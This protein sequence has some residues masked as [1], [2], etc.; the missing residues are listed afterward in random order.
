MR[1]R[2]FAGIKERAVKF[3]IGLKKEALVNV[4]VALLTVTP[5]A[6]MQQRPLSDAIAISE[7]TPFSLLPQVIRPVVTIMPRSC[8]RLGSENPSQ[9][10]SYSPVLSPVR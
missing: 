10:I 5:L 6:V 2:Y 3:A 9:P 8:Y 1:E 7:C 4:G